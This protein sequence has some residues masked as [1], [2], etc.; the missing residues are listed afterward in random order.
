MMDDN[1]TD[2]APV[3]GFFSFFITQTIVFYVFLIGTITCEYFL[4]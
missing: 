4:L 2:S 1:I 3:K